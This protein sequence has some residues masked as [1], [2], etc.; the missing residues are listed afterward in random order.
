MSGTLKLYL[1]YC[2]FHPVN[3][4]SSV[5]FK[6]III[7][8]WVIYY[9]FIYY[10]H[11]LF[12]NICVKLCDK[13]YIPSIVQMLW[14]AISNTLDTNEK[15]K[16]CCR[17]TEDTKKSQIETYTH[18]WAFVAALEKKLETTKLSKVMMMVQ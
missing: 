16:Y 14:Q 17:E 7:C 13:D 9:I 11:E 18:I 12:A 3:S 1:K 15:I 4:L 8:I 6:D 5:Y 2:T 10:A